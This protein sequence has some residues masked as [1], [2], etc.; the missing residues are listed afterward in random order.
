MIVVKHPVNIGPS[1]AL[2]SYQ[3]S[4][5]I[6]FDV[7][8]YYFRPK[9]TLRTVQALKQQAKRRKRNTNLA[10]S[11]SPG[12]QRV[13][14]AR[15]STFDSNGD[16]EIHYKPNLSDKPMSTM[17]EVLNSI[18]GFS[19][20]KFKGKASKKMSLLDTVQMA[21][22]GTI[23]NFFLRHTKIKNQKWKYAL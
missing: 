11:G 21:N 23:G 12:P 8:Y 20:G 19:K 5:V 18:A 22:K 9:R 14:S 17:K 15:K 7:I 3:I 1:V 4:T 13:S 16:I 6:S 10:S 2:F